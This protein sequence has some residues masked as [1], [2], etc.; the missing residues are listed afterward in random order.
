MIQGL[1]AF[2]VC[3]GLKAPLVRQAGED[4]QEF[5]GTLESKVF[6]VQEAILDMLVIWEI[7]DIT[8]IQVSQGYQDFQGPRV[9]QE[10]LME[11]LVHLDP[12]DCKGRR[13][14]A[15]PEGFQEIQV[16][17]DPQ[18]FQDSMATKAF[19]GNQEDQEDQASLGPVAPQVSQV[20]QVFQAILE[21]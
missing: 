12:K 19:P 14:P 15:H 13:H 3:Q 1:M 10:S 20:F 17:Q 4:H 11:N 16:T 18:E 7:Q 5:L 9:S 8:E 2:L 6:Q 21:V